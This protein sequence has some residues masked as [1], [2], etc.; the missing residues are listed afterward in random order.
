MPPNIPKVEVI[1]A[2]LISVSSAVRYDE[3]SAIAPQPPPSRRRRSSVV[4]PYDPFFFPDAAHVGSSTLISSPNTIEPADEAFA[5]PPPMP[6]VHTDGRGEVHNLSVG[7]YHRDGRGQVPHG[8]RI[9]L[10]HTRKE[11]MRHGDF[12]PNMQCGFVFSGRV[13]VWTPRAD[14]SG[15]TQK[16]IYGPKEYIEIPPYVPHV[17]NYLEDTVMAEWWES[18]SGEVAH[19]KHW[20]YA[21]YRRLVDVSYIKSTAGEKGKLHVFPEQPAA[22]TLP[23]GAT[24]W[25]S[26]LTAGA[27]IGAMA[28]VV[29]LSAGRGGKS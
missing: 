4:D 11:V 8:Q 22:A 15:T 27:A 9:N 14:R 1:D 10:S 24:N 23:P 12:H 28:F 19:F 6:S 7:A 25:L 21:P 3:K 18:V 17:Y 26:L 29:G 20:F 5:S 13:E 2:S 16:T